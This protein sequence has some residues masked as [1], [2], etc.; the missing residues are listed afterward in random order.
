METV[1]LG[2]E[3]VRMDRPE[4]RE[5]VMIYNPSLRESY[6]PLTECKLIL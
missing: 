3:D 1:G 5:S 6:L 2:G 4:R